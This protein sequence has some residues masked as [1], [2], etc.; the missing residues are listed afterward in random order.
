LESAEDNPIRAAVRL[1]AERAIV[2]GDAD[3]LAALLRDHEGILREAGVAVTDARGFI[4]GAHHFDTWDAFD[5]FRREA[6]RPDSAT[7]AFEASVEAVIDGDVPEL[8]RRLA[9][10]PELI[11]ARSA[12]RHRATLLIYVGANGVEDFRQRTPPNAVHVARTLL[13]RGAD[14]NAVATMY[15]GSTTLGLVAT[16]VHPERAGVQRALIDL[17]IA[18]DATFDSAV[19][20]DY[21]HGLIINACL[22]NGRGD[23]AVFLA[24]RGARLDLEGA[25]GIGRLDVVRQFVDAAGLPLPAAT[26]RQ[27]RAGFGWACEYGR[28]DVV[29]LLLR[30]P[31]DLNTIHHGETGLHWAALHAHISIVRTLLDAGFGVDVK[32]ARW[33]STP[34]GWAI[35]GWSER[36]PD[37]PADAYYETVMAL[38]SAGAEVRQAWISDDRVLAD[39]RMLAALTSALRDR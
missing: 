28:R 21:T 9:D 25:C 11:E 23:A 10:R 1:R 18:N 6:A 24:E 38:R 26:E 4:A 35:H 20:P 34:L 8:E 15:G 3:A 29:E 27:L 12:R 30:L 37:L 36:Q 17:L 31:I 22:A 14:V 32:D 7:A 33:G 5:A 19:A 2:T 39:S 16:S 13:T